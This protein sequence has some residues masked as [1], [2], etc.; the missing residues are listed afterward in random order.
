MATP[1]VAAGSYGTVFQMSVEGGG[2]T[3]LHNFEE[4]DGANPYG[5]VVYSKGKIYGTTGRGGGSSSYGTVW[6]GRS[7]TNQS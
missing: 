7:L 1:L 5:G 6:S 3:V 4:S 2:V